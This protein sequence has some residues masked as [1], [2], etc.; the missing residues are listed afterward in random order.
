MNS[1]EK[2]RRGVS[3]WK[4][5]WQPLRSRKGAE[6]CAVRQMCVREIQRR[7]KKCARE[8]VSVQ[9]SSRSDCHYSNVNSKTKNISATSCPGL[10]FF[11]RSRQMLGQEM[12]SAMTKNT[13]IKTLTVIMS[14][15]TTVTTV[16]HRVLR[17]VWPCFFFSTVQCLY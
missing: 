17:F 1:R 5:K 4:C 11:L 15:K 2:G 8:G 6:V 9:L 10:V 7:K 13:T 12:R 3:S 14:S 16:Q